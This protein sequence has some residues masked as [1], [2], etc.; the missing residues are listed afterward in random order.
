[1]KVRVRNTETSVEFG[2]DADAFAHGHASQRIGLPV[3]GNPYTHAGSDEWNS[4]YCGYRAA[5]CG[6]D[7]RVPTGDS[8]GKM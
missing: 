4:W 6:R 7:A 8:D 5:E 3:S 2:L 1:M